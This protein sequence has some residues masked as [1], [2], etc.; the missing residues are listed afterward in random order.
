MSEFSLRSIWGRCVWSYEWAIILRILYIVYLLLVLLLLVLKCLFI[1]ALHAIGIYFNLL[2]LLWTLPASIHEIKNGRFLSTY[3]AKLTNTIDS[4]SC[5]V[6]PLR[7]CFGYLMAN[8]R[9]CGRCIDSN[10]IC[11][12]DWILR[13]VS[14][15]LW[16][17]MYSC[18]RKFMER[19]RYCILIISNKM[20][21]YAGIYLLQKSLST[22]FR[23]PLHP[24][25][26]HK[27]VTA[28][29]VT[30]HSNWATTFL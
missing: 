25:S 13:Q 24:S 30:R 4:T 27:T 9:L 21:Q 11:G 17:L 22:C 12:K 29:S 8:I 23:C 15:H 7:V 14:F 6:V 20:Q 28:A 19:L 3:R 2:S 26:E 10:A 18:G 1:A 16:H 5:Y